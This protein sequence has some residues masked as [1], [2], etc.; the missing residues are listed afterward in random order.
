M[1]VEQIGELS[2]NEIRV[3]DANPI[4]GNNSHRVIID[5]INGERIIQEANNTIYLTETP[6]LVFPNPVINEPSFRIATKQFNSEAPIFR[7]FDSR[8][9]EVYSKVMQLTDDTIPI[10]SLNGGIYYYRLEDGGSNY[11][12]RII[13]Q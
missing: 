11:I 5:F 7:L 6:L 12:G 4:Q 3:L 9:I 8:G 13:I 10:E 2:S 1:E